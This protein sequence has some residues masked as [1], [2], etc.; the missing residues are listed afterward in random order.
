MIKLSAQSLYI[1][2]SDM[3]SLYG[4]FTIYFRQYCTKLVVKV[5]NKAI[6]RYLHGIALIMSRTGRLN[7]FEIGDKIVYGKSGVCTVIDICEANF[8]IDGL[9][10]KLK[11]Y[12]DS[13]NVIYISVD[14]EKVLMRKVISS[15]K[16]YE[17]IDNIDNYPAVFP[18]NDKERTQ[19]IHQ[20]LSTNDMSQWL[21]LLKGL[22]FEKERRLKNKR[23][24]KYK[25]EKVYSFL[26]NFIFGEL[27]VALDTTKD[28]VFQYISTKV[29]KPR[30]AV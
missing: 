1:A 21:G 5:R 22:Y 29:S 11:P 24:L 9:C 8:G 14:N 3:K 2:T 6:R 26:E 20:V 13:Q 10:Y 19:L 25:D 12:N 4:R 15:D 7:M 30:S 16:A 18:K 27:A 23:N 28:Q 17:I